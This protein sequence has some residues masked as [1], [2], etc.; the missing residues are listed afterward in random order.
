MCGILVRIELN[1]EIVVWSRPKP[2]AQS[3]KALKYSGLSPNVEARP[4]AA[5]HL[6]D[7]AEFCSDVKHFL[8]I[9]SGDAI[10]EYVNIGTFTFGDCLTHVLS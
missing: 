7:F 1:P 6:E 8:V 10:G 9:L 4:I 3:G 2:F 5:E